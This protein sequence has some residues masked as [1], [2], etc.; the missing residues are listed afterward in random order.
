MYIQMACPSKP[1]RPV[2]EALACPAEGWAQNSNDCWLDSAFYAMFAA[3]ELR[4]EF[5]KSLNIA[6]TSASA[7]LRNFARD[8]SHYLDGLENNAS[9]SRVCK[10][11][12]KK[13][14]VDD[15]YNHALALSAAGDLTLDTFIGR[16][17]APA[18]PQKMKCLKCEFSATAA[19]KGY[20]SSHWREY[21]TTLSPANAE[22][23]KQKAILDRREEN[24]ANKAVR[25]AVL[26]KPNGQKIMDGSGNGEATTIFDFISTFDSN[27]FY[28]R[29]QSLDQPY[30]KENPRNPILKHLTSRLT[31]LS[32][33]SSNVL[34]LPYSITDPR[35]P[36]R[37]LTRLT[38][39]SAISGWSL[40]AIIKG[41]AIHFTA[42]VKCGDNWYFY[43]DMAQATRAR[44][45]PSLNT[46]GWENDHVLI[47][48]FKRTAARGGKRT[49]RNRYAFKR[50][51]TYKARK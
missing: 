46:E 39:I 51:N 21:L 13:R 19:Q 45:L 4:P 27:I 32:G 10:D 36:C 31:E 34:V 22:K 9:L 16:E 25:P 2:A 42:D 6:N 20:C 12:T 15:L 14:I 24:A 30:C 40:Q 49:R 41:S 23:A 18:A 1:W 38:Q 33:S 47:F 11:A 17:V 29:K 8:S 35:G 48:I 50:R 44:R 28:D 43:D 26:G 3:S 5:I 7:A 37:N